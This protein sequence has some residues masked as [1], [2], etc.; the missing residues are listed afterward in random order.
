MTTEPVQLKLQFVLEKYGIKPRAN[1]KFSFFS[2]ANEVFFLTDTKGR[3]LVLKNCLKN[4]SPELLAVEVAIMDH[5]RANGCGA[6]EVVKTKDGESFVAYNGDYWMMTGFLPGHMPSWNVRLKKWHQR[7]AVRGLATYHKAIATLDPGLD[8]GRI[9]ADDSERTLAWVQDLDR[10]LKAD[11]SGR[12]SVAKMLT[13]LPH[14]LDWALR[15]PEFLPPEQVAECDRVMIHGDFHAFNVAYR[16]HRFSACYDFDFCRRDLKV[17]DV[18]WTFGFTQRMFYRKK[19]GKKMWKDDF[20]PPLNEVEDLETASLRWFVG[21]YR[22]V[23]QLSKAEI[24]LLPGL[25]IA[26]ALYNMRFFALSNSEEECL[27]HFGWFDWQR[28]RLERTAPAF[29]KAVDRVLKE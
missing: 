26:L 4:R 2:M 12:D 21:E 9:K 20:A 6:A 14:Y 5:L 1:F 8:T 16:W 17:M 22:K 11:T 25:Q 27:E 7:G 15:L 23:Y 29:Q 24:A 28:K 19:Y 3:K 18:I 10:Q 13:L